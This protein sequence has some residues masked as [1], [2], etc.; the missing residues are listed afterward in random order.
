MTP[1]TFRHSFATH[2][3]ENDTNLRQILLGHSS[4]KTTEIHTHVAVN[5]FQ[6]I[7]NPLAL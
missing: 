5:N 1:H 4:S 7:K 2:L 3:L 6:S